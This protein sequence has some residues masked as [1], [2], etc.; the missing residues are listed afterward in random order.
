MATETP[1]ESPATAQESELALSI[2]HRVADDLAMIVDRTLHLSNAKVQRI[3]RRA[4][5]KGGVHIS[6]K[7]R[8][9]RDGDVQ[10]GALLLPLPDAIALANY[11]MMM[12]DD[13]VAE[14]RRQTDI[15]QGTKDAILEV[16]NFI[17]GAIDAVLR[18]SHP[19]GL[20]AKSAGC[21]G[22][23]ANVRPAFPYVDGSPLVLVRATASLHEF[24]PFELLLM[25]PDMLAV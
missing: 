18:E 8:L 21:Q 4:A 17:G 23:R 22:V 16:G 11:L 24:E 5:G 12:P 20:R 15:D 2:L 3:D 7:L 13:L 9:E 19:G 25:L 10:H 1:T 14:H 6:F